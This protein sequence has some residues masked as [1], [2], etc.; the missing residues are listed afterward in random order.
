MP[1]RRA[2]RHFAPNPDTTTDA[3]GTVTDQDHDPLGRLAKT[4]QDVGGI[5]A[6]TRYEYDAIDNLRKVI[7]PK[8]LTTEYQYDG[9]GNLTK[10][11][12]PDTGTAIYTYDA[13]G[14][15]KTAKDERNITGGKGDR[16]RG[17]R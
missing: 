17:R 14:N 9:L 3:L 16:K 15:R 4:L 10:L 12:R 8:G 11:I 1:A 13:A 2:E 6:E 7:D 5:E